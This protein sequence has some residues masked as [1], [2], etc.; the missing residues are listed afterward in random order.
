MDLRFGR[1]EEPG[2]EPQNDSVTSWRGLWPMLTRGLG[3][4][5][6]GEGWTAIP[7]LL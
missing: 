1:G 2:T 5:S 4:G 6:G 3:L 7:T